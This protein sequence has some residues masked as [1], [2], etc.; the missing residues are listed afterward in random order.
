M[1]QVAPTSS[2]R[3]PGA[4]TPG[5][6]SPSKQSATTD[7]RPG[8]KEIH[9]PGAVRVAAL[10]GV[11]VALALTVLLSLSLGSKDIPLGETW[12]LLLAP[13]GSQ[14][15][16]V[17]QELRIPRTAM[18]LIV[19]VALGVAGALMQSLTRNPL[20]D[21]GIL[22]VNAGASFAVVLAVALTG[23]SGISFYLWFAFAGAA[24][25]S[26][27]VYALGA[28]GRSSATPV[29]LALA[30]VAISAALQALT[31][32]VIL[33]N[34]VAFNEFRFWVAGSLEGRGW[35]VLVLVLPFI[36]VGLIIALL[37][38][39]SLNALALGD[40]TGKALGVRV[41]STRVFTMIAVTLL[42]GA[43]TAAV[44][45]IG[46]VGLAVPFL[47]RWLVGTDQRWVT[48]FSA[49]LGPVWLLAADVVSRL[50]VRPDEVQVGIIA[51][52]IGAPIFVL[53]VRRKKIAAL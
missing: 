15:S 28:S 6:G 41:T 32:A 52:L 4:G 19:G 7:H 9:R 36:V 45:P 33:G 43:A 5:S 53:I 44:G 34:Q 49:M 27:A 10:V 16:V 51:S 22:G 8:P 23:I 11:L 40:D 30:G 26:A 29:R 50:L 24:V 35:D 1:T 39:P 42:A 14:N 25:A 46:F 2:A 38:S 3:V 48:A 21:P 13:D 47:A 37:L 31:E 12:R 17:L 18:G 20:A